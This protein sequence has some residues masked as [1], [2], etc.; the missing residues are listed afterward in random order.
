MNVA[1]TSKVREASIAC[2]V[3]RADGTVEDFGI[4]SYYNSNPLRR[5][6]WHIGAALRGRRGSMKVK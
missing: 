4:V 3:T 1:A 6:A 2:V 5:W